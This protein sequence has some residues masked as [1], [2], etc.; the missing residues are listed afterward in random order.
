LHKLH[1][2]PCPS[3]LLEGKTFAFIRGV[4]QMLGR[5]A[6]FKQCGE[7]GAW[8]SDHLPHFSNVLDEVS[9]L[10]AVHTDQSSHGSAQLSMHTGAPRLGRPSIGSGVT[11]GLGSEDS[12][13]PGC[14]VLTSGGKTPDAGKSV[15]GSGFLPSVYQGGQC[16]SKGNPVLYIS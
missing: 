16:R 6:S 10:K 2:Q 3:S 9:F 11:Y 12:N 15:W 1:H 13:L 5:Q 14:V 8:V 7:S 4:P